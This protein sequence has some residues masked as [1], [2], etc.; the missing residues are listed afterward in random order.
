MGFWGNKLGKFLY[1]KRRMPGKTP[2]YSPF[3]L[4]EEMEG[5]MDGLGWEEGRKQEVLDYLIGSIFTPFDQFGHF[6]DRFSDDV[7][8]RINYIYFQH[9][10]DVTNVAIK[11]AG[12]EA[13]DLIL[14]VAIENLRESDD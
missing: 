11:A 10:T 1:N 14:R 8:M 9:L 7:K 4:T 6:P 5:I 2:E 13:L 3:S 12:I